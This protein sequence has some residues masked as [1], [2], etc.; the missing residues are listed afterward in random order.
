[1]ERLYSRSCPQRLFLTQ[2]IALDLRRS[3]LRFQKNCI[4][5]GPGG[6]NASQ[7]VN[8]P[9]PREDAASPGGVHNTAS[10]GEDFSVQTEKIASAAKLCGLAERCVAVDSCLSLLQALKDVT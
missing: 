1:M 2:R 5:P 7:W 6:S 4:V 8:V 3:L 10:G 9:T